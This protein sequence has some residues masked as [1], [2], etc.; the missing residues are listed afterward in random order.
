MIE[1]TTYTHKLIRGAD[2]KKLQTS[3]CTGVMRV[4]IRDARF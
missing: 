1:V 4:D 3:L 2:K